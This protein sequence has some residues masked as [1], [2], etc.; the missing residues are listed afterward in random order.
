[1]VF[2]CFPHQPVCNLNGLPWKYLLFVAMFPPGGGKGA[3]TEEEG[4]PLAHFSMS[5]TLED[6][7]VNNRALAVEMK[8]AREKG[9]LVPTNPYVVGVSKARLREQRTHTYGDGILRHPDE[10]LII[11]YIKALGYRLV[12]VHGHLD[13]DICIER[14]LVRGRPGENSP[15]LCAERLRQYR[16]YTLPFYQSIVENGLADVFEFG[17][18]APTTKE[19][20]RKQVREILAGYG[21]T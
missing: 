13:D 16:M 21:V 4:L 19:S 8:S 14:M 5:A 10:S 11:P 20:R 2:D 17:D 1:M 18:L 6:A 3:F 15:G 7:S 9:T 12:I